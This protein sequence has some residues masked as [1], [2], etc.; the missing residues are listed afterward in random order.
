MLN[1]LVPSFAERNFFCFLA[2]CVFSRVA[3]NRNI[4]E[5]LGRVIHPRSRLK[6][7]THQAIFYADR[8]EFDRE[9]DRLRSLLFFAD[10]FSLESQSPH[11]AH[12]AIFADRR[13]KSLGVSPA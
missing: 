13:I 9:F 6:P 4:E 10:H 3:S 8:G 2:E 7:A 12:L 5:D 1:F 11:Q